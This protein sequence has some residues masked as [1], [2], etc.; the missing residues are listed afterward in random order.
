MKQQL[1]DSCAASFLEGGYNRLRTFKMEDY[2]G[3][4]TDYGIKYVLR[5]DEICFYITFE[6]YKS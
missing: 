4:Y 6:P 1:T 2:C 3:H 5:A